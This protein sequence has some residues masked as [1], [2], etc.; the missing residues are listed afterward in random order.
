MPDP[1][2]AELA[3]GAA[4]ELRAALDAAVHQ[5]GGAA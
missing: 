1:A 3:S 4:T 5:A 2:F